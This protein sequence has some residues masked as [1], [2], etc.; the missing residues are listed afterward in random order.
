ME[1][2]KELIKEKLKENKMRVTHSR[3]A[4]AEI[5]A[6]HKE[7]F[8]S[9]EEVHKKIEN[10]KLSDCDRVSVYR[11]LNSF[12]ELNLLAKSS[13]QGE[14]IKYKFQLDCCHDSADHQHDHHHH[15]FK[16]DACETVEPFSDCFLSKVEKELLQKGYSRLSHH[17]EIT[18][19][20][21]SCS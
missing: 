15:F 9:A 18:G 4:V 14:A 6:N 11:I 5:L 10:S 7:L 20:C 17:L 19:L 13:F 1:N 8:L 16:C 3:L 2:I 12:D 21:P